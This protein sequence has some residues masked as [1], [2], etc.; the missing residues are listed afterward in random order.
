M[1]NILEY[2]PHGALS[3]FVRYTGGIEEEIARLYVY[4]F[5]DAISFIHKLG[6]AHLDI[7]LENILL[8]KYFNIKVAD[9]AS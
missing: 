1:Y 2:A 4:Q 7:K 5:C 3:N 9:M 8:D 6:Y